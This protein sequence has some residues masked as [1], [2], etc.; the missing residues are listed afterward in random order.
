MENSDRFD[1]CTTEMEEKGGSARAEDESSSAE[2]RAIS[3][4]HDDRDSTW[5]HRYSI[6]VL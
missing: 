1:S 3:T 2:A 6:Q 4:D 5:D